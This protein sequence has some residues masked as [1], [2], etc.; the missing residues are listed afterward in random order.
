MTFFDEART[1]KGMLTMQG[2]SQRR[3]AEMLGVSQSYIANKLRLLSFSG[4]EERAITEGGLSER[5]AR[6]LLRLSGDRR[7]EALTK[8][9]ER[10]L[11]VRECEALVDF[12]HDGEAPERIRRA[13][14][15]ERI[16]NFTETLEESVRTLKSLGIEV[17][18][19]HSSHGKKRYITLSFVE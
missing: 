4:E 18:I 9:I 14:C 17:A 13:E 15:T 12:L 3:L 1:I 7:A 5:H 10:H 8:T 6:A 11:T 2:E 16:K 19:S